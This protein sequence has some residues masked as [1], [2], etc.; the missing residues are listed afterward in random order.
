MKEH[1]HWCLHFCLQKG[2]IIVKLFTRLIFC[3]D[4]FFQNAMN[5]Y[6]QNELKLLST[7][8]LIKGLNGHQDSIM[9]CTLNCFPYI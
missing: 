2:R 4:T 8:Y 1:Q 6:P 5:K 3:L 9:E 7:L